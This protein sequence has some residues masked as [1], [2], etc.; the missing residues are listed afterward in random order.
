MV[1]RI[2]E[3]QYQELQ[4]LRYFYKE[5]NGALGPASGDIYRMIKEA[6]VDAGQILPEDYKDEDG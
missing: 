1:V 5:V 6:W 4:F 3:R 2:N